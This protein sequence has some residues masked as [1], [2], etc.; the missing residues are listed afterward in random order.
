MRQCKLS[1]SAK[2]QLE[3]EV[4]TLKLKAAR[5]QARALA[6]AGNA[7]LPVSGTAV[8]ADDDRE[9]RQNASST[10]AI[11]AS[12]DTSTKKKLDELRT[13]HDKLQLDF[14]K[15][16]RALQREVGDSV[17]L[18]ELLDGESAGGGKRGRAQQIVMLKAKVQK[19]E[20][21]LLTIRSGGSSTDQPAGSA[22]QSHHNVDARARQDLSGQQ[23][24][25]QRLV[26]KLS[27]ERDELQE[28]LAHQAKKLEAVQSRTL[29]LEKEKQESRS[30]LQVLVDKSRNDDALIDALQKQLETWKGRVQEAKRARTAESVSGTDQFSG[31]GPPRSEMAAELERLRSLVTEYKRQQQPPTVSGMPALSEGSQYRV[32]AVRVCVAFASEH[33]HRE[34]SLATDTRRP[35]TM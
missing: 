13:K 34:S 12:A 25:R 20:A 5:I 23:A 24:Q 31:G 27:L 30:K 2:Q 16:Q 3:R 19:L 14:K 6:A 22:T 35:N 4:E 15:L 11:P 9:Q 17:A 33:A 7:P 28:R 8:Q 21:E 1:E 32:M 10:H 18:D 29:T 26:D